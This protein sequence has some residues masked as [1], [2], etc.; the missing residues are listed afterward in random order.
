LP[1]L[2]GDAVYRQR[3]LLEVIYQY[4]R[5]GIFQVKTNNKKTPEQLPLIFS[6]VKQREPDDKHVFR[7][8]ALRFGRSRREWREQ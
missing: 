7:S 8:A 5:D 1:I 4:H 6:G 3:P 2:T